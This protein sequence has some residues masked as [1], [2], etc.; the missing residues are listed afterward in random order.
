MW[1]YFLKCAK[2]TYK[3][4]STLTTYMIIENNTVK[5]TSSYEEGMV[6]EHLQCKNQNT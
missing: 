6:C 1:H 5:S 2:V 4:V 3:I